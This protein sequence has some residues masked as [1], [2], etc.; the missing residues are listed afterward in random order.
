M[1]LPPHE[2]WFHITMGFDK[3]LKGHS[4]HQKDRKVICRTT[5]CK[6]LTTS[7][8]LGVAIVH[9]SFWLRQCWMFVSSNSSHKIHEQSTALPAGPITTSAIVGT[10]WHNHGLIRL[11]FIYMRVCIYIYMSIY[12][13]ICVCVY[14][15]IYICVCIYIYIHTCGFLSHMWFF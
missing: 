6:I 3:K 8:F 1:R 2:P 5:F 12:I 4:N 14:V 15:Y 11:Y 7:I 13:Y 10:I 9:I